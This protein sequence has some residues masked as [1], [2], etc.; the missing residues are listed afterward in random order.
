MHEFKVAIATLSL[1]VLVGHAAIG[2]SHAAQR[3]ACAPE[4]LAE[5]EAA[6]VSEVVFACEGYTLSTC[7]RYLEIR[8]HYDALRES[9]VQCK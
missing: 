4:R 1:A 6:Y 3:P 8:A 5:I 9:W 2:C 7:P